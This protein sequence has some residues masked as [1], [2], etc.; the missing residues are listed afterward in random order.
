M[1]DRQRK[2][3]ELFCEYLN[4][5]RVVSAPEPDFTYTVDNWDEDHN[6]FA[7]VT[8]I[9]TY[10]TGWYDV[11]VY[12][13]V[14]GDEGG[15]NILTCYFHRLFPDRGIAYITQEFDTALNKIVED[16]KVIRIP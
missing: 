16:G 12:E 5:F 8:T 15:P 2:S 13:L 1:T 9:A 14:D 3:I 6:D 7:T 4:Q 10:F 11:E